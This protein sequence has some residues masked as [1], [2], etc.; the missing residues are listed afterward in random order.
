M[1]SF[2]E[3]SAEGKV[4]KD[5]LAISRENSSFDEKIAAIYLRTL[6]PDVFDCY[7]PQPEPLLPQ[8]FLEAYQDYKHVSEASK[9]SAWKS[10]ESRFW[11]FF[12]KKREVESSNASSLHFLREMF[13]HFEKLG[14]TRHARRVK[15]KLMLFDEMGMAA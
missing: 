12:V 7:N 9:S 2:L 1:N 11:G 6:R 14:M 8:G 10:L 5:F 15:Q 3:K 4:A 13:E